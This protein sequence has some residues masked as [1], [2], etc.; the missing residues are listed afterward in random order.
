[1]QYYNVQSLN[2]NGIN[3]PIKRSKMIAKLKR[4]KIGVAFWQET[5]LSDLEHEKLKKMGFRNSFFSSHR[6]GNKRGVAILISNSICFEL[7][8]EHKD[9]EGRFILIR[10]KLGHKEVTLCNV[11]APPGSDLAFFKKIFSLIAAETYGTLICAGDF[12]ILLNPRLDTTNR[13]RK[14]SLIEKRINKMLQELGLID[15]WRHL[16][17]SD[18]EFTFYSARHK[19]HSLFY[20]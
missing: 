11:Y 2:V 12:N 8:S 3:S 13:T 9:N 6:S 4:E 15:I 19:I 14:K 18:Q 7:I 5:H 17:Q 1:M 20:V 10:G 16:H